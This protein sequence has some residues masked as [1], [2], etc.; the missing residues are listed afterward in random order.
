[1]KHH[2]I[3]FLVIS[4]SFITPALAQQTG[5]V[6]HEW[7]T[8][9]T[10]TGSDGILL[11]GLYYEEEYLPYFVQNFSGFNGTGYH[12]G[13]NFDCE[14]VTVKMETPVIYFYSNKARQVSVRVDY[15][16]GALSQWYPS[17]SDG[18]AES[19]SGYYDFAQQHNGWITWNA[20][21]LAKAN[22]DT[23]GMWK[24]G[25]TH[26]WE[27]PRATDANVVTTGSGEVEKY[28]FYRGVGNANFMDGGD[29]QHYVLQT[30]F[31]GNNLII[32]NLT[33]YN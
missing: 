26:V 31:E 14:N 20:N 25:E 21:I 4:I 8:F 18:E 17:R 29:G 3:L 33:H 10:L 19:Y 2:L 24:D 5:F 27:A 16:G 7:G 6:V 13:F 12:K 30:S 22:N 23:V 32:Q 9:T 11:P 28:L 15:P 1:M